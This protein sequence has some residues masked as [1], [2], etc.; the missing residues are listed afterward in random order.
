MKNFEERLKR[1]EEIANKLKAGDIPLEEAIK[2][3]EEGIEISKKLEKELARVE[4]KIQIL[5][6]NPTEEEDEKPK[7]ELFPELTNENEN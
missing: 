2:L 5:V 1:L 6:N 7:L 3:F 4:R